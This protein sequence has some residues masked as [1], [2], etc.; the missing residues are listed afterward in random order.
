[1]KVHVLLIGTV[2]ALAV[3]AAAPATAR[4]TMPSQAILVNVDIT[5]KGIRTAMF[6]SE[7]PK[8]TEYWAAYYAL[9]GE[10]AYFVV[11]NRGKAAQLRRA[12]Q[13]DEV[14]PAGRQGAIPRR[15]QPAREL[16]VPE[17]ARRRQEG[18]QRRDQG[19]LNG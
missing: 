1:M 15:P 16:S 4:T 6:H 12:R 7:G 10:V 8:S 17:H 2:V 11:H 5:D 14:D 9:R 18:L 19:G 3:P 13:E